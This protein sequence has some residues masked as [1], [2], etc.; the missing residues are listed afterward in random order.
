MKNAVSRRHRRL[1]FNRWWRETTKR[2][3]SYVAALLL[4]FFFTSCSSVPVS[5][6]KQRQISKSTMKEKEAEKIKQP[7]P[8]P[9]DIKVIDDVEYIYASNRKYMSTPYE[10]LYVWIRKDE[11]TPRIGENLLTRNA[12]EEKYLRKLEERIKR[13]EEGLKK[14]SNS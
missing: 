1:E 9:G 7:T 13:L 14:M 2:V 6:E 4:V 3:W 11:H 8:E 12:E 10:P 5:Q